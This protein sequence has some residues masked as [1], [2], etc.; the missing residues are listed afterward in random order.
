M[1]DKLTKKNR[2]RVDYFFRRLGIIG[3]SLMMLSLALLLPLN[4][5]II[6]QNVALTQE[7]GELKEEYEVALEK[8]EDTEIV[9][10]KTRT[11]LIKIKIKGR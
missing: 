7:I 10:I 3:G 1:K 8:A 4:A 6:S 11:P 9:V 2:S 5:N